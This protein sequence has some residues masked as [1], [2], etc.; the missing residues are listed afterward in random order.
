MTTG[1]ADGLT[2]RRPGPLRARRVA[3]AAAVHRRGGRHRSPRSRSP[4]LLLPSFGAA[5]GTSA[6]RRWS[7]CFTM[8]SSADAGERITRDQVIRPVVRSVASVVESRIAGCGKRGAASR[9][10]TDHPAQDL[11]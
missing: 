8:V 5:D 9:R 11:V 4:L 10:D 1:G 3:L 7:V 2:E 6:S